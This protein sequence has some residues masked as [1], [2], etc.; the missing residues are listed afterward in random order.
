MS[1]GLETIFFFFPYQNR[2]SLL[3][4]YTANW[5]IRKEVLSEMGKVFVF[6]GLQQE[7]YTPKTTIVVSEFL[8]RIVDNEM[9]FEFL[10]EENMKEYS[11]FLVSSLK[12]SKKELELAKIYVMNLQNKKLDQIEIAKQTVEKYFSSINRPVIPQTT[13]YAPNMHEKFKKDLFGF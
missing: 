6:R 10:N 8:K 4:N 12:P 2:T 5:T 1:S 7:I 11:S 13:L 9:S 3:E